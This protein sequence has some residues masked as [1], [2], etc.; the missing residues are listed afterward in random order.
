M[1]DLAATKTFQELQV[2]FAEQVQRP[3]ADQQQSPLE[4]PTE[5]PTLEQEFADGDMSDPAAQATFEALRA[6]EADERKRRT[7]VLCVAEK[8]RAE[9]AAKRRRTDGTGSGGAQGG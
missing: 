3:G 6:L 5:I 7:D 4:P 2:K 1:L 8:M 9:L